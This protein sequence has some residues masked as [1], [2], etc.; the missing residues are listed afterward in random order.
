[1]NWDDPQARLELIERVGIGEYNRLI[2]EYLRASVISTVNGHPVRRRA[3]AYGPV[4]CVGSV[5]FS[6][7]DEA[8]RHARQLTAGEG[9]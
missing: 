2:G 8:E 9:T 1:M 5:A 3:S 7:L 6:T 4:Y